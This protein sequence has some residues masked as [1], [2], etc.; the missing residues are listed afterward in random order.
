MLQGEGMSIFLE[1]RESSVCGICGG[2]LDTSKNE[3]LVAWS[4][5]TGHCAHQ[6]CLERVTDVEKRLNY[7][8]TADGTVSQDVPLYRA[9]HQFAI[10]HVH[11]KCGSFIKAYIEK[12]STEDVTAIINSVIGEVYNLIEALDASQDGYVTYGG[13]LSLLHKWVQFHPCPGKS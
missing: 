8:L 3:G 12:T 4:A 9:L 6:A 2:I 10:F 5:P 7:F 11:K 13:S 1:P